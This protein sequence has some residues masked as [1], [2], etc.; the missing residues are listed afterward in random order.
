MK[1]RVFFSIF[2]AA[3]S[4]NFAEEVCDAQGTCSNTGA[5]PKGA[6]AEGKPRE[7]QKECV[8]RY[9]DC[10]EY[11]RNGECQRNPG[12]MIMNCPK[13]CDACHLRDPAIRCPRE[14]LNMSP[15][16]IYRP[17]DMEAMFNN[18]TN[19]FKNKY[20]IEI[21]STS[22]WI[23]QFDNFVSDK[24]AR[25]LITTVKRWERSTD[26]GSTNEYGETGRI[27]STGRT[28]SNAW[29]THECESVRIDI[30]LIS[31]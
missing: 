16:P 30:S 15:D 6:N 18:I 10:V 26:T 28:S 25:A 4:Y 12:W 11:H 17:G 27:L 2:L 20:T 3:V 23:V 31:S 14:K 5:I 9:P 19:R 29:C 1:F 7:A 13:I 24:E 22:P 8:D 21:L